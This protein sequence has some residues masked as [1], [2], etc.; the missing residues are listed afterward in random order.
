[1]DNGGSLEE[2]AE[3]VHAV[4]QQMTAA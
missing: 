3:Q 1:M 2:P 4:W